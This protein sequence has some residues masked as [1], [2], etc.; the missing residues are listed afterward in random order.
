MSDNPEETA[1]YL[2]LIS[3]Y[4][5]LGTETVVKVFY[6]L[7]PKQNVK[8]FF[9]LPDIQSA[10][11]SLSKNKLLSCK[12]YKLVSYNPNPE[13]FDISL[14]VTLL[15]NL[16]KRKLP[17]PNNGWTS[18]PDSQDFSIAADL[19]RLRNIRNTVVAH[20]PRARLFKVQFDYLSRRVEDILLRLI[21]QVD[22]ASETILKERIAAY[23]EKALDPQND[24]EQEY[25]EKLRDWWE[26]CEEISKLQE[27]VEN[28]VK[29]TQEFVLFFKS[30]PERYFRYIKLLFDGGRLVLSGQLG[31]EVSKQNETLEMIL[32]S[33]QEFLKDKFSS[34]Q[35]YKQLFQGTEENT[36]INTNIET[37][38]ITVVAVVIISIFSKTIDEV[39]LTNVSS[40]MEARNDYAKTALMAL[41]SDL[42]TSC[43]EDLLSSIRVLSSRL[44]NVIYKKCNE[45]IEVYKKK[46]ES[47]SGDVDHYFEELRSHGSEI[48]TIAEVYRETVDKL[49]DSVKQMEK[50]GIAFK[51]EHVLELKM[52]TL[53]NNEEKKKVAEDTLEAVWQAALKTSKNP[54]EFEA[55]RQALD[56][57]LN[58]IRGIPDVK[59]EQ[60]ER[61]CILLSLRCFSWRGLLLLIEYFNS[62]DFERHL[63][64]IADE[65]YFLCNDV[66]VS[67]GKLTAESILDSLRILECPHDEPQQFIS[68]PVQCT[69]AEGMRQVLD[70]VGKEKT[71]NRFNEIAESL[72]EQVGD[73]IFVSVSSDAGGFSDVFEEEESEHS[74][75][76]SLGDDDNNVYSTLKTS[77]IP[78]DIPY[79]KKEL[80]HP[81]RPWISKDN[82][83]VTQP[84]KY[85]LELY[86]ENRRR[87][88]RITDVNRSLLSL[89][90]KIKKEPMSTDVPETSVKRGWNADVNKS[91]LSLDA[92]IKIEPVS[93]HVPETSAKRRFQD[94]FIRKKKIKDSFDS[95]KP[96][97]MRIDKSNQEDTYF[98]MHLPNRETPNSSGKRKGSNNDDGD[99]G[100]KSN[101]EGDV[102]KSSRSSK[103]KFKR[104]KKASTYSQETE[105]SVDLREKDYEE[106]SSGSSSSSSDT[107]SYHFGHGNIDSLSDEESPVESSCIQQ[108]RA[109]LTYDDGTLNLLH[110]YILWFALKAGGVDCNDEFYKETVDAKTKL[111]GRLEVV[112]NICQSQA[113]GVNF[114]KDVKTYPEF[115]E[116]VKR[117]DVSGGDMLHLGNCEVVVLPMD[118][119][120]V[121]NELFF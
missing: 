12:E 36:I 76:N 20:Q 109:V 37:W 72:S 121:E 60:I 80:P 15:T 85:D 41:D 118:L 11:K 39:T 59:V 92:K 74:S 43:C 83:Q 9:S 103:K 26:N 23:K 77:V 89:E 79:M 111:D 19:L 99:D 48:K 95:I 14:L 87:K 65:L 47:N 61:H 45:V 75:S 78:V 55:V 27:R 120:F 94:F 38:D 21:R 108:L 110:H 3:M 57:I 90:A 34:V 70:I 42:F 29:K 4:I 67:T 54:E 82:Q 49:K 46:S 33:N 35:M 8:S 114:R 91:L 102:T 18:P 6:Y 24:G 112:M 10:L 1:Y 56:M 113:W 107:C 31:S 50:D 32:H 25:L 84:G 7:T 100:D 117:E 115:N 17:A 28:L 96:E 119:L 71:V 44:G 81:D 64:R 53:G 86:L 69:S 5:D 105:K 52:V 104:I 62:S 88:G 13:K 30:K 93:T 22:P 98:D 73:K 116:H 16:Y 68:L 2:R 106:H 40:I 97:K 101:D 66:L 63:K 58:D 51:R